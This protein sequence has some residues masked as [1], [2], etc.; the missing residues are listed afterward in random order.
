MIQRIQSLYLFISFLSFGIFFFSPFGY[1]IDTDL[2]EIPIKITDN[3]FMN[4]NII[5]EYSMLPLLLMIGF[6]CLL[7]FT[8]IFL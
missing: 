8:T 3:K 6:I 5:M 7:S 2:T 1:L 4:E